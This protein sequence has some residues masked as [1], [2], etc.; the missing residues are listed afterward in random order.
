MG[1]WALREK[2]RFINQGDPHSAGY[3]VA[4]DPDSEARLPAFRRLGHAQQLSDLTQ[5]I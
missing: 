3:T 5:G 4:W 2:A 1:L